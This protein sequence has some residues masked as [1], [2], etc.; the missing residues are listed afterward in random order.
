MC[1]HP[2][3]ISMS[4][5]TLP[6]IRH[7]RQC[8]CIRRDN[9]FAALSVIS[10]VIRC[11]Y[12]CE[13]MI[14]ASGAS[15]YGASV[16]PVHMIHMTLP[17]RRPFRCFVGAS[18]CM[19]TIGYSTSNQISIRIAADL[20][21][22]QAVASNMQLL[23]MFTSHCAMPMR[24]LQLQYSTVHSYRSPKHRY[25]TSFIGTRICRGVVVTPDDRRL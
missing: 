7:V 8:S 3:H 24:Y 14:G 23:Y 22:N 15:E 16:A 13:C 25:H 2:K 6:L 1:Q 20:C 17:M 5:F 12:I 9:V 19:Y 4:I 10:F 11:V 18:S 21:T